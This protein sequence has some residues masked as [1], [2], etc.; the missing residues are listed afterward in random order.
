MGITSDL[1]PGVTLPTPDYE[2]LLNAMEHVCKDLN[3]Q[4][5]KEFV[6]KCIQ[7]YDTI[8][9]RHGLM[10]VGKAFS[11]KS[12]VLSVLG[13]AISYIKDDPKFVNVLNYYVNP[14]SITQD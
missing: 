6:E 13:K 2:K 12:K 5:K 7:L 14:K 9:V 10:V 3:L 8:M 11:G 1:F 4:Y